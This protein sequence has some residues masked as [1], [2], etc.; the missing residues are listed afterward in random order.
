[1]VEEC[2]W[3]KGKRVICILLLIMYTTNQYAQALNQDELTAVKMWMDEDGEHSLY[4]KVKAACNNY[5]SKRA[6]DFVGLPSSITL[7]L[8][9]DYTNTTFFYFH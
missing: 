5:D 4:I 8:K 6:F 9:N 7:R 2:F 1:M 3:L